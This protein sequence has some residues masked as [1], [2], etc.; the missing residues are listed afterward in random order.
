MQ[1]R[2]GLKNGLPKLNQN[3][4]R[5]QIGAEP[6]SQLCRSYVAE[7]LWEPLIRLAKV[8][9][10]LD[11]T[12]APDTGVARVSRKGATQGYDAKGMSQGYDA[13]L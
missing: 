6:M 3:G 10:V 13:K 5:A 11:S 7:P 9:D 8:R 1:I 12:V 4:F 2:A